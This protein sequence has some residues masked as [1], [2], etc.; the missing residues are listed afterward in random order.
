MARRLRSGT[1][2][3]AGITRTR[4]GIAFI[5]IGLIRPTVGRLQVYDDTR[6]YLVITRHINPD[7]LPKARGYVSNSSSAYHETS[8]EYSV[9]LRTNGGGDY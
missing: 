9:A 2:A 7:M 8:G 5:A 4:E 6:R 3:W 1:S